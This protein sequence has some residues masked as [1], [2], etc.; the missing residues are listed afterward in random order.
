MRE[1][2]HGDADDQYEQHHEY[3]GCAGNNHDSAMTLAEKQ[4]LF[5]I[6]AVRLLRRAHKM[7]Y[8]VAFGDALRSPEE[9]K[10]LTGTGAGIP[11]SLHCD[12]LALDVI[13]RRKNPSTGKWDYL[14]NSE[15]YA[16]LGKYWKKLDPLCR[17][18]GDFTSRPDGNHFSLS[19]GGRA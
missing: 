3:D 14:K 16:A 7:G 15:D 5:T 9:A 17:W 18:G 19:H 10:R 6:L 13:L 4:H 12:R 8:G 2:L 1:R 11:N